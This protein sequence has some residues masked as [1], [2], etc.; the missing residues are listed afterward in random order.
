MLDPMLSQWLFCEE[1][2]V[3]RRVWNS[4]NEMR[5]TRP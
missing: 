4:T 5:L 1:P 3:C 2:H